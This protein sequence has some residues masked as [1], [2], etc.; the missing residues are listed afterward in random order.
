MNQE[1]RMFDIHL[2]KKPKEER[3][4]FFKEYTIQHP[5]FT[6]V[7]SEV[8]KEINS[9]DYNIIMVIGPSRI[10]KSRMVMELIS[11]F[12]KSMEEEIILNPGIIPISGMELPNPDL[13]RF[14]WKD[15]YFRVLTALKEPLLNEKIDITNEIIRKE[16]KKYLKPFRKDTAPELRISL[17]SAFRNRQ[18]RAFLIDE[19]Q[20]FFKVGGGSDAL[21]VQFNS[22]KS[23]SNM[24]SS[25]FVM[26]GTYDLNQVINLDGQL[27][28]RVKEVHFPRY[29]VRIRED[30][31]YFKSV[32]YSLQ[33]VIPLEE[34][35]NFLDHTQYLYNFSI[36]CI[37]LLKQWLERAL[38]D[39][40]NA[41]DKTITIEHL[42]RNS[43][44][45]KKVLTLAKEAI[46]GEGDF[47]EKEEDKKELQEILYGSA[48]ISGSQEK[49]NG[50][51]TSSKGERKRSKPG[52]RNPHRD[53]VGTVKND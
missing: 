5:R 49:E 38:S 50:K 12:L 7:K 1:G 34:E 39:A 40:L 22:I 45:Q 25:K 48:T 37:G 26:F 33:K 24:T 29:D 53:K 35:P 13:S 3:I 19:A 21:N 27:T 14:N 44:N 41:G 52:Q 23:L 46:R 43:L 8:I 4:N 6:E 16:P 51:S 30:A 47:L 2:L 32:V 9:S 15:F 36:G 17:E 20:H 11:E 42:E 10:G 28:S 31:K 18:T